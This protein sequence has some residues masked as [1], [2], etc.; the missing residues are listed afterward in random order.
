MYLVLSAGLELGLEQLV[1]C[2]RRAE[3]DDEDQKNLV[4]SFSFELLFLRVVSVGSFFLKS[5]PSSVCRD[6]LFA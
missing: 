6:F 1:G 2:R 4:F 5:S 3:K